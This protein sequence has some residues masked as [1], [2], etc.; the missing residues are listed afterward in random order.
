MSVYRGNKLI[1]A[2]GRDVNPSNI[3]SGCNISVT[4]T[5]DHKCIEIST[6]ANPTFD[7]DVT[8]CCNLNVTET[9]NS[10][11]VCACCYLDKNG[12][13]IMQ[14]AVTSPGL[15]GQ[16]VCCLTQAAYD[17]LVSAGTVDA[18]TYYFTPGVGTAIVPYNVVAGNGVCVTC[19]G[20][21]FVVT[22]PS[23]IITTEEKCIGT[24]IDGQPLYMAAKRW[25]GNS[26]TSNAG[27]SAG[28]AHG[29]GK[30]SRLVGGSVVF[31]GTDNAL[32]GQ[33]MQGSISCGW[34]GWNIGATFT[35]N[36]YEAVY[37][38]VKQ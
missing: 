36:C 24:W 38:Y 35:Y 12:C 16:K 13:C 5:S 17:A 3:L 19:S 28:A 30:G 33:P 4:P 6:V 34:V 27:D 32:V 10:D 9:V 14:E 1:A 8:M 22:N 25:S 37:C 26:V 29:I 18:D 2:G 11:T 21:D 23:E 15:V 31:Y 7:D 20:D